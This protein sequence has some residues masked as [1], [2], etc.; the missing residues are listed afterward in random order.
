MAA[1]KVPRN[2]EGRYRVRVMQRHFEKLIDEMNFYTEIS[3]YLT[4]I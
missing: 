1:S 2:F 3:R 4:L